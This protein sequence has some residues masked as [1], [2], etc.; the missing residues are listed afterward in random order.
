MTPV[1]GL[2]ATAILR[3]V[4][5]EIPLSEIYADVEFPPPPRPP[6]QTN[7]PIPSR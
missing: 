3:A 4:Q 5:L 1:I 6:L 7:E 2:S